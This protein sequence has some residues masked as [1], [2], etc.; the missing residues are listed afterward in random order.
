MSFG[1]GESGW[2][3]KEGAQVGA[4][5]TPLL[6]VH[7]TTHIPHCPPPLIFLRLAIYTA[8]LPQLDPRGIL[9]LHSH[10]SAVP[11][12]TTTATLTTLEKWSLDNPPDIAYPY[13]TG[14]EKQCVHRR[15]VHLLTLL[16]AAIPC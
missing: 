1:V 15:P 5:G 2:P 8:A 6:Y 3:R 13:A 10:A 4:G 7:T 9:G 14:L 16:T 12:R 11:R